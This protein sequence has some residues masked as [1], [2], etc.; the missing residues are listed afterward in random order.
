MQLINVNLKIFCVSCFNVMKKL[1]LCRNCAKFPLCQ[2][3]Q[4]KGPHKAECDLITS[5]KFANNTKYSVGILFQKNMHA[6]VNIKVFLI[7][8][9]QKHLFRASTIIKGL[10]LNEE[11][12]K[13][14]FNM[15]SHTNDKIQCIEGNIIIVSK[16]VI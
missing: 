4:N 8:N 10:L 13:I 9:F 5:W 15:A 6:L 11:E 16:Y 12:E 7:F 1:S 14:M 2:L 3:C